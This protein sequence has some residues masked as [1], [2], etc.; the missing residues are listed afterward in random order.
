MDDLSFAGSAA[1]PN[2]VTL[3]MSLTASVNAIPT[4]NAGQAQSLV[5]KLNG[6]LA[7]ISGG[8]GQGQAARTLAAV[9]IF[10]AFILEVQALVGAGSLN[11]AVGQA[12]IADAAVIAALLQ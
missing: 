7:L 5:G 4:I 12:L 9:R 6:A 2:P 3:V 10:N 11:S 1:A 8:Q